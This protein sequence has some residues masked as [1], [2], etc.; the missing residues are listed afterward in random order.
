MFLPWNSYSNVSPI[1]SP[2]IQDVEYQFDTKKTDL[3]KDSFHFFRSYVDYFYL[4]IAQ[5]RLNLNLEMVVANHFGWCVG[6]AHA[7][8]FGF[9]IQEDNSTKFTINDMDDSGSCLLG[10]DLLRQ[11][12]GDTLYTEKINIETLIDS[13]KFGL[14]N[15]ELPL[16]NILIE[17]KAKSLERLDGIDPKKINGNKIVRKG[18]EIEID[19]KTKFQIIETLNSSFPNDKMIILDIFE[20]EKET[21]GSSGLSRFELLINLNEKLIYLELKELTRPSVYPISNEEMP[22]EEMRINKTL[23]VEQDSTQSHFYKVVTI[24]GKSMLVRPKFFGNQSVNLKGNTEEANLNILVYE[25][26]ILGKLHSKSI[27]SENYLNALEQLNVLKLKNDIDRISKFIN[28][29][30]IQLKKDV[31][32]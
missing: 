24:F 20:T 23:A 22:S 4:L 28:E 11:L 17:L 32:P 14:R 6:D 10:Y 31:L 1:E 18:S 29:K 15:Q 16:P 3:A 5:N 7:E 13:Y 27:H 8:N 12:V 30:F 26:Y 25:A 9:L 2:K 21:G 19:D